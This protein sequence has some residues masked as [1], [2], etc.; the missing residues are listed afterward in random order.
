MVVSSAKVPGCRTCSELK[1]AGTVAVTCACSAASWSLSELGSLSMPPEPQRPARFAA[2]PVPSEVSAVSGAQ[3]V[4]SAAGRRPWF[5]ALRGVSISRAT[6]IYNPQTRT[7]YR[8]EVATTQRR[9]RSSVCSVHR[10]LAKRGLLDDE[11][12]KSSI[13]LVSEIK[14]RN[15][16]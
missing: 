16:L 8:T 3:L 7:K 5:S 6:S 13:W 15:S 12:L 1:R 4:F 10:P 14:D 11:A 9:L 2:F